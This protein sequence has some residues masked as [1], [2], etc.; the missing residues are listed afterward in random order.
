M[1]VRVRQL[2]MVAESFDRRRPAW[3]KQPEMIGWPT[4]LPSAIEV[5]QCGL[6][7]RPSRAI[8]M[9]LTGS[10][11]VDFTGRCPQELCGLWRH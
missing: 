3:T 6:Y 9:D 4:T 10:R 11:S 5:R 7:R 8:R 2:S 1:R